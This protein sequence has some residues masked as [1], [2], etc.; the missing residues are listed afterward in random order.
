MNNEIKPPT[1]EQILDIDED[2]EETR[3]KVEVLEQISSEIVGSWR[4]GDE[5]E[6][7]VRR[8]S[9]NT[10]WTCCYRT[11]PNEGISEESGFDV[12]RVYPHQKTITEYTTEP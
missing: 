9:D 10:F 7:T 11:T 4:H 12:I 5:R 1:A 3:D 6:K 2:H 8:P